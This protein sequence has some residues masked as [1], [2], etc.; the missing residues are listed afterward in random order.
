MQLRRSDLPGVITGRDWMNEDL[1]R[2][3]DG[4]FSWFIQRRL[5]G[6][7]DTEAGGA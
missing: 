2:R 5:D 7:S 1:Q 6:G 4:Y 3:Y